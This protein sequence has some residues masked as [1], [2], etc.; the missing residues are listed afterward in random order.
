[1]PRLA[2]SMRKSGDKLFF[3]NEGTDPQFGCGNISWVASRAA[4][5]CSVSAMLAWDQRYCLG[6][7]LKHLEF[8]AIPGTIN[9]IDRSGAVSGAQAII[10]TVY[11]PPR[12]LEDGVV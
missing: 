2:L 1:M 9:C 10:S 11:R 6:D 8:N 7:V 5:G 3:S 12:S 4:V